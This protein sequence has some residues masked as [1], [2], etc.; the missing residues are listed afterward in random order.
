MPVKHTQRERERARCW[1]EEEQQ[2]CE[3]DAGEWQVFFLLSLPAESLFFF[4]FFF[5][6]GVSRAV[7]KPCPP[8]KF[9]SLHVP[10]VSM[11]DTI[12][13]TCRTQIRRPKCCV[14]L[15][16]YVNL[17]SSKVLKLGKSMG[18]KASNGL[19]NALRDKSCLPL[20]ACRWDKRS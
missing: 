2:Q 19:A 8:H 14:Q 1:W 20:Y 6:F 16:R 15:R 3:Y 13:D 11:S 10:R 4:F 5:L 18:L 17:G 12:C 9:F 7:F